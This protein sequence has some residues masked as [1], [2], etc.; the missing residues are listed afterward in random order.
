M[1][2][3]PSL[4]RGSSSLLQVQDGAAA[5]AV[6]R[7]TLK[8]T[9]STASVNA[10][11]MDMLNPAHREQYMEDM[12]MQEDW[13]VEDELEDEDPFGPSTSTR[14]GGML[15]DLDD[16]HDRESSPPSSPTLGRSALP[17]P[18]KSTHGSAKKASS[19]AMMGP[20]SDD[21]EAEDDNPFLARGPPKAANG[22]GKHSVDRNKV[23]YVL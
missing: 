21:E 3:S 8:R 22:K 5:A 7:G 4:G 14:S 6:G 2:G 11:V 19:V 13:E 12:G 15:P 1:A 17:T 23:S 20:D 10:R 18:P 9:A 16:D